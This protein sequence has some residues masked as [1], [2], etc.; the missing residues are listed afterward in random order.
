MHALGRLIREV[1]DAEGLSIS[2]VAMR[3]GD[4]GKRGIVG[5]WV[6]PKYD[7]MET[8]PRPENLALL[9]KALRRPVATVVLATAEAV[10]LDVAGGARNELVHRLPAGTERL[11]PQEQH[12]IAQMAAA[13][14]D[15]HAEVEP[16]NLNRLLI[17]MPDSSNT[18]LDILAAHPDLLIRYEQ[19]LADERLSEADR[20]AIIE[21]LLELAVR[22][23][24]T[25]TDEE[26]RMA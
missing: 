23:D 1:M 21:P 14:I 4:R 11:S 8:W 24:A 3:M 9:A 13:L 10:G 5:E 7:R 26:H 18:K 12:V 17:V 20:K 6:N 16:Y 2:D 15:A 25:L 19:A 22:R